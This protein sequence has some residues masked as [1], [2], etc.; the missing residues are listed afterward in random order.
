MKAHATIGRVAGPNSIG[1]RYRGAVGGAIVTLALA[2]GIALGFG[3]I[4][5]RLTT[6]YTEARTLSAAARAARP[7]ASTAHVVDRWYEEPTAATETLVAHV[8]DRWYNGATLT[9]LDESG[10]TMPP[11]S[12]RDGFPSPG[13]TSD[14]A[15]NELQLVLAAVTRGPVADH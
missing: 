5:E 13:A 8:A 3:A 2:S 7:I 10:L 11:P 12:G 9:Q 4:V 6:T 14:A 1:G 15:P